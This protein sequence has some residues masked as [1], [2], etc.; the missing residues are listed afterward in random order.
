MT[1]A[2]KLNI[3]KRDESK[4]PRELRM[5]GVLPGTVY[6]KGIESFSVQV[7]TREFLNTYKNNKDS[8]YEVALNGNVY[9]TNVVNVQKNYATNEPLNIEFKV[10]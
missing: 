10:I 7:N 4:N 3:E 8:V 2:I 1:D 6:G 5:S 9:S